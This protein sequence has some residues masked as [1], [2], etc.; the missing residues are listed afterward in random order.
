MFST[1]LSASGVFLKTYLFIAVIEESDIVFNSIMSFSIFV[2]ILLIAIILMVPY[3]V[4]FNKQLKQGINIREIIFFNMALLL[5]IIWM[6]SFGKFCEHGGIWPD[7]SRKHS[8]VE[9]FNRIH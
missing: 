5:T 3:L 1:V 8:I 6:F 4:L 9:I 7:S 2:T